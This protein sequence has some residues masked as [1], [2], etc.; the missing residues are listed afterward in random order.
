MAKE[1][2]VQVNTRRCKYVYFD[3]LA[4][5]KAFRAE[6]FANTNIVL[7]VIED[8]RYPNGDQIERVHGGSK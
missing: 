1:F 8:V 6:V 5:A 4:E 3:T 2:K 7:S